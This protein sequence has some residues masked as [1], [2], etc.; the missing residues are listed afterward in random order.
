MSRTAVE[1]HGGWQEGA[2]DMTDLHQGSDRWSQINGEGI[3]WG[4]GAFAASLL[5]GIVLQPVR[6]TVGLENA[7]IVY[8]LIV[9]VAA[10]YGGRGAGLLAALAAALSYDYFLT[11]P[12]NTLVI[13]TAAQ[14]V[15]VGLLFAAGVVASLAGRA[16]RRAAVQ[17]HQ[18]DAALRLLNAIGQELA[19]GGDADAVAA[20]GLRDLLGARRVT[21][22]HGGVTRQAVEVEGTDVGDVGDVGGVGAVAADGAGEAPNAEDLPRLD[23]QGRLPRGW[24]LWRGGEPPRPFRGVMVGMVRRR[25][26]VGEVAVVMGEGRPLPAAARLTLATV[27]HLLA[28]GPPSATAPRVSPTG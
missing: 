27:A 7:A 22:R 1:W 4:A 28:V 6:R 12:Y 25:Q 9:I 11:T 3:V 23:E 15:T 8:L 17:A 5:V 19:A 10:A 21:I 24:R 20:E 13:D 16:R 18:R 14:V 2:T 26:L